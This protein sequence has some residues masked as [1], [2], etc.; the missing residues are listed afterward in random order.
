MATISIITIYLFIAKFIHIT[1]T[2]LV[3]FKNM[4]DLSLFFFKE[5]DIGEYKVRSI[6]LFC[7][8]IP[9]CYFNTHYIIHVEGK[10]IRYVIYRENLINQ[11]A[12]N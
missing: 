8:D 6:E 1:Y 7:L 11:I 4:L 12:S 10:K 2:I 5:F 9:K 3:L